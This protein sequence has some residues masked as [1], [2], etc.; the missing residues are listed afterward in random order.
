V[1]A[2]PTRTPAPTATVA[3][4]AVPPTP[5]AGCSLLGQPTSG[6]YCFGIIGSDSTRNSAEYNA[7]ARYKLFS[8][9]WREFAP[10]EGAV[11]ANYVS[12]KKTELA[13]L[14]QAGLQPILSLGVHDPPDW[15]HTN[16]PN[17]YYVNQFGDQ[18]VDGLDT[19]DVNLMFNPA[20]RS[21]ARAYIQSVLNTFGADF[22]AI[23]LGGGRYGELTY[24][25]ASWGGKSNLYW[26]Y[27]A[28]ALAQS[29]VPNWRPGDASPNGEARAFLRWHLDAMTEFQNWQIGMMRQLGYQGPL[30]MLY[31]S[32][33]IRPGDF[34]KAVATNLNG[35]SSAEIN[36]EIARGFDFQSQIA[37]INDPKVIVTSTWV[38]APSSADGG[39]DQRYWSPV[40]YLS[41]LAQAHPLHLSSFGENTGHGDRSKMDLTASR[42]KQYHLTGM[43]RYNESEMFSGSYASL[44]DYQQVIAAYNP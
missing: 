22:A 4:T 27:D 26:N 7:G 13:Q 2:T 33:G 19:G 5:A 23:R 44:T 17:S 28:N 39:T 41:Y 43:L 30:M 16:Y 20:M 11:D 42:M 9:R 14:R 8:L 34:D 6:P 35:S 15:P 18:Y 3:P 10:S 12:R 31:P 1:P 25:P 21:L 36:G 32:W 29:P 37:A 24:P 38:D 40:H